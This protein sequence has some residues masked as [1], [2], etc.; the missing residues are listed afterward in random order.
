MLKYALL[1]AAGA[2]AA[3]LLTPSA[4]SYLN[5]GAP[6]PPS[7]AASLASAP[8]ATSAA[9]AD[10]APVSDGFRETSIAADRG[11]QFSTDVLIDGERVHMLVDTG[12]TMVSISAGVAARLGVRPDPAKPKWRI[13]TANGE[14]IASP[15][16]LRSISFGSLYMSDVEALV[17]DA[18]AG[19]VN[20]LGANFLKRLASVEQRNG[21][22]ILRQ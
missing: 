7:A 5:T 2:L 16:I 10:A 11:G 22:L 8:P 9:P 20:L 21:L 3:A 18:S 13:R 1:F 12:A 6:L 15:A 4:L 19:E 17:L 14:T